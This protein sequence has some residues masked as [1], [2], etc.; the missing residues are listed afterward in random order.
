M[1]QH[2]SLQHLF[3]KTIA[4][5]G[6]IAILSSCASREELVYFQGEQFRD[7]TF[8]K[9]TPT[10][11][12]DDLLSI[13]VSAADLEATLPFNQVNPYTVRAG[14]NTNREITYLIDEKGEIDYPVLGKVHL[15]GL[16][17]SQAMDTMRKQLTEYIIDPGV[18][19]QITNFRVTVI[20]EV[21]NP[22][23][24]TLPNERV[25]ILE[26]LGMAGDLTIN[27]VRDNVLVIREVDGKKTFTRVDLTS[28]DIVKSPVYFLSQ[29]DV[30]YV[31]P[32]QAQINSSTYSRNTSIVISVAG[33]IVSVIAVLAR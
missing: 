9:Y 1:I 29:N 7:S 16:T 3:T 14:Q 30:V 21:R 15:A 23:T 31:E 8:L 25:T 6:I 5:I 12:P 11:Q 13:T 4:T 26:A 2:L 33:L 20:G 24:F 10:L 18:N 19:I 32:N 27:G 28:Q 22:G 17:R